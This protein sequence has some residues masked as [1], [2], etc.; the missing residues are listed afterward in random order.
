MCGSVTLR[1]AAAATAAA[2]AVAAAAALEYLVRP[3]EL[4]AV[5]VAQRLQASVACRQLDA[6][7]SGARFVQIWVG[8]K[9]INVTKNYVNS[10]PFL[11]KKYVK[12]FLRKNF[13]REK[14]KIRKTFF[15]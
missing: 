13:S 5:G 2:A 15:T 12:L 9:K 6:V 7:Q 1:T 14:N 8:L 3:Q 11:R 10:F 4:L